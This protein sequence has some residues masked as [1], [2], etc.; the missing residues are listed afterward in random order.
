MFRTTS[1]RAR[2]LVIGVVLTLTPLVVVAALVYRQ[3]QQMQSV[4]AEE[5]SKLAY[6]D[7]DH[8]A[9]G[10]YNMCEAQQ[11]LLAQKVQSDLCVARA[12][13]NRMGEVTLDTEETVSWEAINQYTKRKD[14]VTLPKFNVGGQWLGQYRTMAERSPV[15]DD[16]REAVG[17]TATIFQ[18]MNDRGDMLRV[19]TNVEKTDGT[20]AIGTFIPAVNPDG[21]PN[22]VVSTVMAGNTFVGRAYVVNKWY[23]TA[24]EP[25]RDDQDE[26]IGVL[27]VGVPQESVTALR[28]RIMD[29]QVGQT[30]YVYVLDSAGHYV[31][32]KDG[33]RDGELIWEAR[34]ADG[35]LF[36]QDIVQKAVGL[37]AG[38]IAEASYPWKNQGDAEARVKVVRVMYFEPWDWV[39]GAGSYID[40]FYAA[41]RQVAAVGRR[42]NLRLLGVSSVAVGLACLVWFVV[43][44][45][46]AARIMRIVA[47]LR[48]GSTQVASASEQVS[49]SSQMLAQGSTEQASSLEEITSSME[50][51]ASQTKQN[52]ASAAEARTL[53]ESAQGSADRGSEAMERMSAAIAD[54]KTSSDE[55]AKIVTTIDEIAFQTNLLALNAAVEAAR[56][57]E[58]GKGF[59][60]VAEEVR[61]LAQRSAEAARSTAEMIEGSVKN[62]DNG[63]AISKDVGEAL[64]EIVTGNRKV[65]ELVSEISAASDEQTQGIAQISAAVG[66]LDQVTQS[67]AATA[68]ESASSAEELSAQA[69]EMDRLV[70]ELR[71]VIGGATT[72]A[73]ERQSEPKTGQ[74]RLW[75]RRSPAAARAPVG[76]FPRLAR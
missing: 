65:G 39:I 45:S 29:L 38:E 26:I 53:A 23:I 17:G 43:A 51:M 19:C 40:E 52:S 8:I 32:S 42:G 28:N 34:D 16:V 3:N 6:A 15:V 54:I 60:V 36:I 47:Q 62:A 66:Q 9:E 44:R 21:K 20:R 5:S 22:P 10:V 37:S 74:R 57:G 67:S 59:A 58:A 71:Q 61:N 64:G 24:Y 41:E 25:I 1:L 30:G 72:G 75:R 55:T 50:E 12:Y 70:R 27:Y 11:A 33:K 18:K 76:P 31:I 49:S 14:A 46:L 63:V 68:E 7:L 56:A 13:M 48:E 2:L 4:A 35:N 69:S 73:D